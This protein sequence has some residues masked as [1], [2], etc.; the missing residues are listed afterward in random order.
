MLVKISNLILSPDAPLDEVFEKAAC[1]L[2]VPKSSILKF[3]LLRRSIDARRGNVSIVYTVLAETVCDFVP[4][5]PNV[6][7]VFETEDIP[8][9][10]GT[11]K[12]FHRPVVVGFGPCGMFCA[13]LLSR[14]G[15]KPLV[16]ERGADIDERTKAVNSFWK[17]GVLNEDTNVQFGE[18]GAGTFSDGKLT[19]RIGDALIDTVLDEFVKHGAPEDILYNAM[20]HIGTD[21]LKDVVKNIREEIISLGGEIKFLTKVSDINIKNENIESVTLSGGEVIPCSALILAIGHS[22]RDTYEMLFKKG[23][24]MISKPFSVGLRVE[25]LREDIDRAMYGKYAENEHLGAAPYKLSYRENSKEGRGCYSFC[26]CPGGVVVNASSEEGHLVVNGMSERARDKVNSNS[27]ICVSVGKD[28][29]KSSHP[30][31]GIAFQRDLERAAFILGGENYSLPVQR[32]GDFFDG[33]KS[34]H[35]GKVRPSVLPDTRFS[36]LNSLF[37]NEISSFMKKGF[38]SFDKKIK[39]F[40][41]GDALLTGVETRTSA[42]VRILRNENL[43]CELV[44]GIYPAGEGAGYAGGIVSAAVDGLKIAGKIITKYSPN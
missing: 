42:P 6:T 22:A 25:H 38:M 27:A 36:D 5:S 19:T 7:P 17:T 13:L 28:D 8:L 12:L 33:V 23:L 29:F 37:S 41:D 1:L 15:F 11:E 32:L 4:G 34:T 35:F 14:Y 18:G 21:I 30:L 44:K 40:A 2:P 3:K 20:P 16:L 26:M 43:E 10:S 24:K 9:T 39:G 31:S